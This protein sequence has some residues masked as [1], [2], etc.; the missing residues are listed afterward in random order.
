MKMID[1]RGY[2]ATCLLLSVFQNP[3]ESFLSSGPSRDVRINPARTSLSS[4]IDR[5]VVSNPVE[6]SSNTEPLSSKDPEISRLIGLEDDRQRNGLELI[7]SENFASAAVKEVL[8]SCLTNKYSEGQVGKRYYGGN[9]YIDEIESLCMER[10]LDLF[11]LDHSDWG[12]NVQPY[13]GSPANFAVYTALLQPHDR[14]MGLDLPSGGHLTHGFQTP[15]KKVS[16][17]SVYFESM[18]YVVDPSTGIVDY[19]DMERRAKMFMPK[20]LIAGGSAYTREWDYARMRQIADSIGAQLMVDMAHIS[21]LVAGKVVVNPF[22][23]ADVVT[24]TTHK[25]LRGPRS[26]MIFGKT[27]LMDRIN[28]AV[29]PMLQGGPHNHQIAALAVALREASSPEFADYATN[30]IANAK[31]LGEGLVSRGHKLVTG[32]TDN[33]IILWDVKSTT[34]LTGSKVE[35]VLELAS[36]TANKNSIP[37][38][39]SAINPGGVRLGSPALTTRGLDEKDFDMVAEFLHQGSDL[40]VRVNEFAMKE[41]SNGKVLLRDFEATLKGDAFREELESLKTAVEDFAS[42]FAMP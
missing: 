13:S 34:G 38:D 9:E 21:G 15:K 14:I 6:T 17:T 10:A 35:R 30:V 16:A 5:K 28:Q 42:K 23:Y 7:A 18:P 26:G 12:V 22:E 2:T 1:R 25:T 31:A 39:T 32:G 29:F 33:H 40:A 4:T 24:S 3:V 37:G 36:I 41:S 11:G 19:D 8:G 27:E 20:L